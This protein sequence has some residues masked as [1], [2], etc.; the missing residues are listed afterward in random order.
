MV[1]SLKVENHFSSITSLPLFKT[2]NLYSIRS[3]THLKGPSNYTDANMIQLLPYLE[4]KGKARYSIIYLNLR[5]CP[6]FYFITS[7]YFSDLLKMRNVFKN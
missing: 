6:E 3:R 7:P 5:T 4:I 1:N 2:T